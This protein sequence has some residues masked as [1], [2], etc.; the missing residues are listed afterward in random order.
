MLSMRFFRRHKQMSEIIRLFLMIIGAISLF[1]GIIGIFLPLLPTTPFVLLTAICW[2]K[3]SKKF[4]LWLTNHKIFGSMV[5]NWEADRII[6]LKAKWLSTIMMN[7]MI[8]IS[9]FFLVTSPWWAKLAMIITSISISIWI[10][11]FPHNS[12][13]L[14]E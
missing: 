2:S 8:L 3:G 11:S 10:W 6:P 5:Q 4:H 9:V 7:G 1:L 13:Q 12:K 14:V